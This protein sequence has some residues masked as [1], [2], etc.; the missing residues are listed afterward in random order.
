[1]FDSVLYQQTI[2]QHLFH[3]SCF[4]GKIMGICSCP[5]SRP[6]LA[7][8]TRNYTFCNNICG[9]DILDGKL[10]EYSSNERMTNRQT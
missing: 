10:I 4:R 3:I 1:M 9:V 7:I 8:L 2:F 5:H 6:P